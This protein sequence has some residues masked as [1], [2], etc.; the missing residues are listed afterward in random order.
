MLSSFKS[1]LPL[2]V[3]ALIVSGCASQ[4]KILVESYSAPKEHKK[5]E[6]MLSSDSSADSAGK[7]LTLSID[8]DISM[9]SSLANNSTLGMMIIDDIKELL[10]E[11]NFISIHPAFDSE[12]ISLK[13]SIS[14]YQ[15]SETD[16][17]VKANMRVNFVISQ[18]VSEFFS[19]SYD[20][21]ETRFSKSGQG[22]P[23]RSDI[24][25]LLSKKCATQFVRDISPTKVMQLR[26]FKAFPDKLEYVSEFARRKNYDGG[27]KAMNSYQGKKDAEFHYNLA[28]LYEALASDKEDLAQLSK[29]NEHYDWAMSSGGS[30]D[31]DIIAAKARFDSFYRLFAKVNEQVLNNVGKQKELQ[32]EYGISE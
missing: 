5:I 8:P 14:N 17:N 20:A 16:R 15:Y 27:I 32:E 30:S 4:Q 12:G 2:F 25:A 13:M 6:M 21:K 22:L 19:K 23:R 10:T 24:E 31:K 7:N 1:V 18:G 29:A 9:V 26:V 3:V 11:T 28:V